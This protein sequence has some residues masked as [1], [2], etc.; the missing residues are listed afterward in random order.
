[1][2]RKLLK[3]FPI[4]ETYSTLLIKEKLINTPILCFPRFDKEFIIRTDAFY[5]SKGS[6]L[7]Q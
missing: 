4:I 2:I 1:M 3:F 7:L 6:V 5:D